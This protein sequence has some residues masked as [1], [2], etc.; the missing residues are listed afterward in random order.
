MHSEHIK[1]IETTLEKRNMEHS[2]MERR[3]RKDVE[4]L[5]TRNSELETKLVEAASLVSHILPTY[6]QA[7]S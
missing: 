2:D 7:I 5:Q 1:S 4:V 6:L 3:L